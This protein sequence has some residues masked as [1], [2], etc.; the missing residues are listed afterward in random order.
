MIGWSAVDLSSKEMS[1]VLKFQRV[2]NFYIIHISYIYV[3]LI[4][5]LI[6]DSANDQLKGSFFIEHPVFVWLFIVDCPGWRHGSRLRQ[7]HAQSKH[8]TQEYAYKYQHPIFK[9]NIIQYN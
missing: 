7:Q 1:V 6:I 8:W 3:L 9:L 2:P 4:N 5:L